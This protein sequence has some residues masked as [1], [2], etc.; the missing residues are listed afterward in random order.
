MLEESKSEVLALAGEDTSD[1]GDVGSKSPSVESAIGETS[2]E[3]E[4]IAPLG[5][6]GAELDADAFVLS[7]VSELWDVLVEGEAGSEDEEGLDDRVEYAEL[8]RTRTSRADLLRVLC[9]TACLAIDCVSGGTNKDMLCDRV[10]LP[11]CERALARNSIG[12]G[13]VSFFPFDGESGVVH[14]RNSNG[15][16]AS[17]SLS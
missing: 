15:E 13:L 14:G 5:V 8:D 2:G 3:D 16:S 9:S 17:L 1:G 7:F 4:L 10:L 6:L 11:D 12:E